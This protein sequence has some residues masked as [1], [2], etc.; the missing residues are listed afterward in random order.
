[1]WRHSCP[2][3]FISEDVGITGHVMGHVVL[4]WFS[5]DSLRLL[6]DFGRTPS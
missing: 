1:M 5:N 3:R 2:R 6:S 4:V